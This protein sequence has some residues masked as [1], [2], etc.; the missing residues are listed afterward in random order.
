MLIE[1]IT[2]QEFEKN[3][4]KT[5]GAIIPIGPIE[6]HGPH[7]PLSSDFLQPYETAKL[8]AKKINV[9]VL[10]PLPLGVCKST[11]NFVGTISISTKLLTS[12]IKELCLKLAQYGIRKILILNGHSGSLHLPAVE[13]AV[14]KIKKI[15]P[16]LKINSVNFNKTYIQIKDQV[17]EDKQDGH[18]G[19]AE[20]SRLMYLKGDLVKKDKLVCEHPDI[21]DKFDDIRKYMKTGVRGD[22]TKASYKKGKI[23][24][25]QTI[26]YIINFF[27]R[28]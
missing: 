4:K 20:T 3:L 12:I 7:L 6:E 13:K 1:N 15:Y 10:P 11:A 17:V 24:I 19:E 9:F 5:K 28:N 27:E 21:P 8:V 22:A 25:N 2:W 23:L 18:S 16:K 26:K 14:K